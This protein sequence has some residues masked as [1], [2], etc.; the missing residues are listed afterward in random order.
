LSIPVSSPGIN[1]A[2]ISTA[3][4]AGDLR[5]K[6]SAGASIYF[7]TGGNRVQ[8]RIVNAASS[9]NYP[10]LTGSATGA[11]VSL[12]PGGSDTNI[13]FDI[14]G[15]GTGC[16][17]TQASSTVQAGMRIPHGGTPGTP[18]DGEIWTTTAGLFVQI[19]GATVGPLS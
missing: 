6:S 1:P 12:S 7:E 14:S 10:E 8:L 15:K 9:V 13:D 5:V 16:L 18:R 19:N 17:V 3:N 11:P 2:V 4:G